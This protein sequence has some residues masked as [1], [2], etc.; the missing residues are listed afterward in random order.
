ME[1]AL[2]NL[3]IFKLEKRTGWNFS[4]EDRKWLESR[5]Q[6]NVNI[7]SGKFHIFDIP[8]K[9]HASYQI[10]TKL[11]EILNKYNNDNPSKEP[12]AVAF[13]HESNKQI[14][15]CNKE[16]DE[17]PTSI[18]NVKWHM[19]VPVRV[20][21]NNSI[22]D[23]YYGCFINTYT[24]SKNNIPNTVDG[25]AY[26]SLDESGFHGRFNLFDANINDDANE[27]PDW[28]YI[29]G[30]GFYKMDGSYNGFI[31]NATFEETKFS[32]KD[33]IKEKRNIGNNAV[34]EVHFHKIAENN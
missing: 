2:G 23:M 6:D 14:G 31:E 7:T 30:T 9:I 18:W 20:V 32:I 5:R 13:V 27:H 21:S 10:K 33:A 29:I 22:F 3:D 11:T 1:I 12:L 17:N 34:R 25:I 28:N 16:R 4:D 15:Q 19:L 8:F 26:V 24:T